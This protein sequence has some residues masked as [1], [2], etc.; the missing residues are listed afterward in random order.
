[1]TPFTKGAV[2]LALA[3]ALTASAAST[4]SARSWRPWAA[5]GAGFVAGAAVGSALAAP[6]YSYYEPGYASYAYS[7]GYA[8]DTGPAYEAYAY[9][10]TVTYR[11]VAPRY[12]S[13]QDAGYRSC[14]VQGNY[15]GKTD[16]GAC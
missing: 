6:R 10:P 15:G 12:Y 14:A 1:M 8:Y 4:A 13:G 3:G 7:P 9:E 2:A 11:T 5:A 16:Y